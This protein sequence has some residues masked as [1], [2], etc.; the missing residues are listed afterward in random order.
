MRALLNTVIHGDTTTGRPFVRGTLR[1]LEHSLIPYVMWGTSQEEFPFT[2]GT[3]IDVEYTTGTYQGEPQWVINSATLSEDQSTRDFIE[4]DPN[5]ERNWALFNKLMSSLLTPTGLEL[6]HLLLDPLEDRF[7][8][9][10]AG[11][12]MHDAHSGGLLWHSF[13]VTYHLS[14]AIN[15]STHIKSHVNKDV[16]FVGC[17]LHD[18]GKV[19]EYNMG[20]YSSESFLPHMTSMAM[21]VAENRSAVESIIGREGYLRLASIFAQHHGVYEER[22]R[23]VEAMLVHAADLFDTTVTI[24][25]EGIP[26]V[27][28]SPIRVNDM[29]VR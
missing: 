15:L 4:P 7:K 17:A 14:N 5:G 12:H 23:T 19:W 13:K 1:S 10:F 3:I 28:T 20:S 26:S 22:C 16:L 21:Y 8:E 18:L 2:P 29:Y 27:K 11:N 25:D 6:F 9:E 24:V